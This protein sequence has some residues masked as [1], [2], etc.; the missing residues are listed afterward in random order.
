MHR[1]TV[2]A[3]PL[4]SSAMGEIIEEHLRT[5]LDECSDTCTGKAERQA[6]L[7]TARKLSAAYPHRM[8]SIL[9]DYGAERR[10]RR[11]FPN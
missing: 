11:V 10:T 3:A 8:E 5:F 7:A 6:G 2:T 4:V 1:E 9:D